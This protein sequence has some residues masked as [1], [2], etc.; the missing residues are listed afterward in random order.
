MH[1]REH[2]EDDFRVAF[3]NTDELSALRDQAREEYLTLI[4][5]AN[6]SL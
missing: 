2:Q 3:K 5:A 6:L 4:E 1:D